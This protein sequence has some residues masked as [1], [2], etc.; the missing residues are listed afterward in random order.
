[1][2]SPGRYK[3]G[4]RGRRAVVNGRIL[5]HIANHVDRHGYGISVRELGEACGW[6]SSGTVWSHLHG[7][8]RLGLVDWNDGDHR[9]LHV[10]AL[11]REAIERRAA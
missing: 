6:S 11:G 1:M 8:R 7:L 5:E 9:T 2:T 4:R 10:T 3:H